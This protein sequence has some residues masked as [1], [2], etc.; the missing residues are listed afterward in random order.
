MFVPL[1]VR[2]AEELKVKVGLR[3]AEGRSGY[4][5]PGAAAVSLSL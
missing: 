3:A 4:W 2:E 1:N 5:T